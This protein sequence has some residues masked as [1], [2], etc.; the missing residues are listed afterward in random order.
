LINTLDVTDLLLNTNDSHANLPHSHAVQQTDLYQILRDFT[1]HLHA[2]P[3][4]S[5]ISFLWHYFWERCSFRQYHQA[6]L[7]CGSHVRTPHTCWAGSLLCE[8]YPRLLATGMFE[9]GK[10]H[11]DYTKDHFFLNEF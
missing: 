7:L 1:S 3:K 10:T 9:R 8:N 11:S 5:V 2:N 6:K 4:I